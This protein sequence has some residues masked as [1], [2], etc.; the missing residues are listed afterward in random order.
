M[1]AETGAP[2]LVSAFTNRTRDMGPRHEYSHSHS[3]SLTWRCL[4]N[5]SSHTA[6]PLKQILFWNWNE[7]R[8]IFYEGGKTRGQIS[9]YAW[10]QCSP[11]RARLGQTTRAGGS[12]PLQ[13]PPRL[14]ASPAAAR[15]W[16]WPELVTHT[17]LC[18]SGF[19]FHIKK[20]G[21]HCDMGN[22]PLKNSLP[23]I[24]RNVTQKLKALT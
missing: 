10:S 1:E 7:E 3:L 15:R 16:P 5:K 21:N 24:Q 9:Q 22:N 20:T 11:G 14:Q 12:S 13:P 4:K 8:N 6:L 18:S 23:Q 2:A 17:H 19:P